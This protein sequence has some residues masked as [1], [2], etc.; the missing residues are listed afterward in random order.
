M[1][2]SILLYNDI[3]KN[4]KSSLNKAPFRLLTIKIKNDENL[5]S[6]PLCIVGDLIVKFL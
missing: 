5:K 1:D 4:I 6:L 3:I 2:N